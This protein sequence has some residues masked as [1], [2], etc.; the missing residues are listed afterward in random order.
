MNVLVVEDNASLRR[1]Y[2]KSLAHHEHVVR[3]A[4]RVAA[5][6]TVLAEM[7]PDLMV[8]DMELPDGS[9]YDIIKQVRDDARFR[10]TY[11]VAISGDNKY[12]STSA[13]GLN[14]DLFLL[15]PISIRILQGLLATLPKESALPNR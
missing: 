2:V 8:V 1:L 7:T 9:G 5:A 13:Q 11:V 10:A 12:R 15:K 3:E 6:G 14:A 4:D